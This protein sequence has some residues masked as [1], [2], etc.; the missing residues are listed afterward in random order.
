MCVLPNLS[1]FKHKSSMQ[2]TML[3][4]FTSVKEADNKWLPNEKEKKVACLYKHWR[5]CYWDDVITDFLGLFSC[6]SFQSWKKKKTTKLLQNIIFFFQI[7][8][9]LRWSTDICLYFQVSFVKWHLLTSLAQRTLIVR[10]HWQMSL[11]QCLTN[12]TDNKWT[13]TTY[14]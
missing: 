13:L 3:F 10:R 6:P 14:R 12:S 7:N 2:D 1:T 11:S 9:H 5:Y 4:P 8:E